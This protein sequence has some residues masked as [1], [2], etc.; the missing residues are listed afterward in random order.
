MNS[1]PNQ[2]SFVIANIPTG[3]GHD[4]VQQEEVDG[5][6]S[7][8]TN[9]IEPISNFQPSWAVENGHLEKVR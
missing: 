1:K 2:Q 3:L 6:G 8:K 5:N 7:T 4:A 9:Y